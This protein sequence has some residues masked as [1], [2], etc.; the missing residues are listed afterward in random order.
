MTTLFPNGSRRRDAGLLA[1]DL[2]AEKVRALGDLAKERAGD[3]LRGPIGD[4]ARERVV[5]L[6]EGA[7]ASQRAEMAKRA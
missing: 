1:A 4:L 5:A 6:F 2:K 3:L 7:L